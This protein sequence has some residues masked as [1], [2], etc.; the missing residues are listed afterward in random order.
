MPLSCGDRV[1]L[2]RK[3]P[4]IVLQVASIGTPFVVPGSQDST[5]D[6]TLMPREW[7]N[8][9]GIGNG[10][11]IEVR[12]IRLLAPDRLRKT[13]PVDH[14]DW[15]YKSLTGHIQRQR[16]R[17]V[18]RLMGGRRCRDMLEIGY[19]SGVFA[20][21]LSR[22][23]DRYYG[24]D[25][26]AYPSEIAEVLGSVGVGATLH[27]GTANELPFDDGSMDWVVAVS[28]F[29]FVDDMAAACSEMGR[30]LRPGG[31]IFVVTPGESAL[32]DIGLK[33]A[34]GES[35]KDDF[36]D[37]RSAV[38]STLKE[39]FSV[40]QTLGYPAVSVFGTQVYRSLELR[41]V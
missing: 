36:G 8:W 41:K 4:R 5:A 25:P 29:E 9:R 32:L 10:V 1:R 15:N 12:G 24:L 26:H 21:E 37:R 17:L 20:P 13:G 11:T 39:H 3:G 27:T 38:E 28:V 31:S 34:T 18:I 19:G 2:S 6:A 7:V 22:H 33:L 40:A 23:C 30:V 35:A 16:F 14:A